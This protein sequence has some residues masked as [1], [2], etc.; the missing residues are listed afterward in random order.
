MTQE[1]WL[2][3]PIADVFDFV[4]GEDV[5]PKILTGYGL[6]PAVAFTSDV[7]G[8]WDQVGSHRI[9]HLADGST[10]EESV[11]HYDHASYFAYRVSNPSFSLKHLMV[12]ARGQFWFMEEKGGT[13]VKW[14]YSFAAKNRLARIP[15]A[16]FVKTQWSGYMRT[17]LHNVVGNF[18]GK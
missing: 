18:A 12:D 16:L 1:I 4:A 13:R 11:T 17:C 8:P 6:V 15:L 14:T 10:A 3:G 2:P 9:V 7:S 5:L